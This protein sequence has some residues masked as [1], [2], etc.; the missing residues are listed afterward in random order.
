MDLMDVIANRRAVRRFEDTSI[1]QSMIHTLLNAA[2][3]APSAINRQPW[4]FAV[5]LDRKRVE[6]LANRARAWL[7]ENPGHAPAELSVHHMASNPEF[8]IFHHAPALV[9][10]LAKGSESQAAEDCC[11]AAENLML[12][13]H[14]AG[15]GTCPIGLARPW[16][17]LSST[18]LELG[19]PKTYC[20][21]VP[22]VLGH[23]TEWPESPGRKPPEIHW[24][25]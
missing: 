1:D 2:I 18:K 14:N 11:L 8:A 13:A 24:I 19:V 16:L 20:V 15:L 9:I 4:A 10:V 7:L 6:E 5:C 22:I 12:A 21:V 25:R 3:A 23:P 17:D